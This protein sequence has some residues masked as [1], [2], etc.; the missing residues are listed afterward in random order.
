[1]GKHGILYVTMEHAPT[2]PRIEFEDWYNNEHGPS[3]IRLPFITSGR[4][5]RATDGE[6]PPWMALYDV[7]ELD[8]MATPAYTDLVANQSKREQEVFKHIKLSK[9]FYEEELCAG[10]VDDG[11]RSPAF[12]M[13]LRMYLPKNASEA[14]K[15]AMSGDVHRWY[16]DEHIP[17]LKKIPGWLRSRRF[18]L[19]PSFHPREDPHWF[20]IH[21]Y[22]ATH[23][24]GGPAFRYATSTVWRQ[25]IMTDTTQGR[26][27]YTLHYEFGPYPRDLA[28]LDILPPK[29]VIE[30]PF[31]F[32]DG[33]ESTYRLEGNTSPDAPVVV[34]I[35]SLMT[36]K[37]I[38]DEFVDIWGSLHPQYR[39][40]RY[41]SRGRGPVKSQDKITAEVLAADLAHLLD[42]LKIKK[43]DSVIGVS[44]GGITALKFGLTYPDRLSR[45][46]A[47]DCTVSS[48][49]GASAAWAGRIKIAQEGGMK[50]LT[51]PTIKRWFLPE[52][53]EGPSGKKVAAMV[54]SNDF[55]GFARSSEAL[56]DFDMST[57]LSTI[58]CRTLFVSGEADGL[59]P[60]ALKGAAQK[61]EDGKGHGGFTQVQLAGHLPMVENCLEFV[62]VVNDFLA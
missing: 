10:S 48:A 6:N 4:R 18:K 28:A 8:K 42:Q 58:K 2:L 3:R 31:T 60:E 24:N 43:V 61:L 1:M 39:F 62:K 27:N 44:L 17:L 53:V 54:S 15:K 32:V 51:L 52:N 29:A 7:T 38:W 37:E 21:E 34:F 9:Y 49:A 55:E 25:Q 45:L 12:M 26:R 57:L 47:C 41:E 14:E 33:T 11:Y 30:S 13:T 46:V 22:Q 23:G 19:S 36:S 16:T 56:Y 40:L 5:Y 50:A 35:N 59:I 20:A